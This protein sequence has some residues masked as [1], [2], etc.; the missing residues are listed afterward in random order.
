MVKVLSTA[1][2]AKRRQSQSCNAASAFVPQLRSPIELGRDSRIRLEN[3]WAM[4]EQSDRLA[5]ARE[6]IAARVARF[7]ATQEKFEREREEYFV[8]TLEKARHGSDGKAFWS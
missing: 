6:E 3:G 1:E 2:V 4:T 7:K 8:T 5:Q